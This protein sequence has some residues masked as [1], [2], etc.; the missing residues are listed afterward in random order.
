MDP[1]FSP[2]AAAPGPW[3]RP[4]HPWRR[5]QARQV[6][7]ALGTVGAILTGLCA[8][9]VT[10][11]MAMPASD[12]TWA[13]DLRT[14]A[15]F[16]GVLAAAV[17]LSWRS[18]R[19]VPV[20]VLTAVGVVLLPLSALVPAIALSWVVARSRPGA[21]LVGTAATAVAL[22]VDLWRDAGRSA[23]ASI[24]VVSTESGPGPRPTTL[25]YA[26][27]GLLVL[28]LAIGVGLVRR[29]A[30]RADAARQEASTTAAHAATLRAQ[31]DRLRSELSRQEERELIA[32]EMHDTVAHQLSLVS[33]QASALE[34]TSPDPEVGGAAR[35][36][37]SAAHRALEEMRG[38]I[39]SLRSGRDD[40]TAGAAPVAED[41]QR[42]VDEAIEAGMD[43]SAT[44][45]V[46]DAV[47]APS[48][49][50]RAAYRVLQ[51]CLTNAAKHAPGTRVRVVV[52]ASAGSGVEVVVRNPVAPNPA[53]NPAV[54]SP[55]AVPGS[56]M[57][58]A[59]MRERC[60]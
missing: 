52:R 29:L 16:V 39:T 60:E 9:L 49:A 22:T 41:L 51:E 19:P 25:G 21:A 31:T 10:V 37:R 4:V 56:G 11:S 43:V 7:A 6:F 1:S 15:G 28:V 20:C 45:F 34:V 23:A 17:A 12:P 47:Q 54:A 26:L 24:F 53:T 13:Q 50:V 2:P 48:A 18:Q 8:G 42:L 44:M 58:L 46:S 27:I 33:L 55:V 57:G 36:M 38:L 40:Y 5:G 3:Q 32:R 30:G 59:G 14:F 35:S